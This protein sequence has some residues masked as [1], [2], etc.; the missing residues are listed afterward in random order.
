MIGLGRGN[1]AVSC[2][3]EGYH[4]WIC[5]MHILTGSEYAALRGNSPENSFD[6]AKL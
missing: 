4:E 2:M 5:A 3:R 6:V 1:L